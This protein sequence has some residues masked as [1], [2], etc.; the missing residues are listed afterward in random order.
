LLAA[1]SLQDS[2]NSLPP[3][4]DEGYPDEGGPGSR[5]V[6]RHQA[7]IPSYRL[8]C[9]G[10][11]TEWGVD[12]NPDGNTDITFK[13]I[14]QV[15]RP[16]P[17]VSITGCYSLVDD[18]IRNG[19]WPSQVARIT[20]AL[21]DQL[22][23]QPGDVLGF[24]VESH[25]EGRGSGGDANNG[26]A[27]L[28]SGGYTNELVWYGSIGDQT[29]RT[30][31]CPYPTGI[32]TN[33]ILHSLTRAAPVISISITTYSCHQIL[34]TTV[35][36]SSTSPPLSIQPSAAYSDSYLF[37]ASTPSASLPT[38]STRLFST[39]TTSTSALNVRI[40][41]STTS[42]IGLI[43]GVVIASIVVCISTVAV[44]IIIAVV[45]AKRHRK[46]VT[47]AHDQTSSGIVLSNQ[48]YGELHYGHT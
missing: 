45:L 27:L 11:I 25:G 34:S 31:S 40:P 38:Y 12:L 47:L 32:G 24:Y 42:N 41:S 37:S 10:N 2:C 4:N 46:I 20:P 43:S 9:C 23:F 3:F 15:W 35:L 21:A 48:I 6:H 26:V 30:G 17:N 19:I 5:I 14:F 33:R 44:T 13:F 29:S 7:I 8:N 16:A 22:Q 1:Q 18:F 28:T 39:R 36:P